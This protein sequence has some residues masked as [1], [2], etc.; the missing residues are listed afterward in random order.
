VKL[1]SYLA[2]LACLEGL[3][4]A[5]LVYWLNPS[6]L[7]NRVGAAIG[8]L[9]AWWNACLVVVYGSP[10]LSTALLF[11]RLSYVSILGLNPLLAWF[12]LTFAEASRK[13][14][15]WLVVPVAVV[16]ATVA[17]AYLIGGFPRTG[18]EPGPWGNVGIEAPNNVWGMVS[19]LSAI[20]LDFVY[21]AFLIRKRQTTNSWRLKRLITLILAGIL[22]AIAAYLVLN[23]ISETF[24]IPGLIFLPAAVLTLLNF[25]VIAQY[26]FLQKE[27]PRW[28]RDW[29]EVLP[30][31]AF[32]LD[33]QARVIGANGP[34]RSL[35]ASPLPEGFPPAWADRAK[36][37]PC[38][39]ETPRGRIRLSPHFDRFGDFVGAVGILLEGTADEGLSPRETQVLSLVA[40]GEGNLAIADRL[41]VS[42]GTVKRH[43]H[44]ILAKTGARSRQELVLRFGARP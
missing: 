21:F 6:A 4:F 1:L 43:V 37:L 15:G 20:A 14:I 19:D 39:V 28:E 36:A 7:L 3:S 25:Y 27:S 26:R 29:G 30:Q 13:V 35:A 24:A 41:F 17:A 2:F 38:D 40:E 32:L 42:P 10:D 8:L 34:A 9:N 31:A 16:M 23:W 12:Y 5:A 18:F 22:S 33:K 11:D 44:A